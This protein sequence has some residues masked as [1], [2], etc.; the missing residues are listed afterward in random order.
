M[1]ECVPSQEVENDYTYSFF[2][3]Q[4]KKKKRLLKS[5]REL[6]AEENLASNLNFDLASR[7]MNNKFVL[8]KHPKL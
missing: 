3:I 2:L 4:E 7:T 6:S 5:Q 8:F 1:M